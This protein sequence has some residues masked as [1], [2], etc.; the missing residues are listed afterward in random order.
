MT[1]FSRRAESYEQLSN[2]QEFIIG[3]TPD[4]Q[5]NER[6][7]FGIGAR[8]GIFEWPDGGR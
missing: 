6:I 2:E 8:F 4:G 3:Q 7:P 5:R 1:L